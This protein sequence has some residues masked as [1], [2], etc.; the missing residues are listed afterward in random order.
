MATKLIYD[1]KERPS[2]EDLRS[3]LEPLGVH[4]YD[5][6]SMEASDSYGFVFSNEP[7]TRQEIEAFSDTDD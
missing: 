2:V 7:M 4:V 3:A 5:D 6:P 1:W